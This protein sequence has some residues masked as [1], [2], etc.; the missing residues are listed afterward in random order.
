MFATVGWI[1]NVLN[2]VAPAET[3]ESYDNVGAI[4]GRRDAEVTKILVALDCTLDVVRE[5]K[6]L[7]AELI[8][9]HHPL[10]FHPRKN[11]LEEDAEGRILCEMVRSHL[12]LIAA[13][14]NL[15]QTELSGSASCA[16]LLGL[17]NVRKETNYLFLGEFEKPVK[18]EALEGKIARALSFPVRCYGDGGSLIST[19]AIAGGADDGD[20]QEAKALGAQALL[21]GEVRH[22][23]ALAASMSDFVLF[24]GGHYGTEA[25]LVPFLA[26]YLQ[27]RLNDVQCNV[28]VYP[29]QCAPFGSV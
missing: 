4:I 28:R 5:A 27:K 22:H 17:Q 24:D 23:N 13:H 8:V 25:P 29:S 6:E 16:R 19:L 20:W 18:A 11:L 12:S 9:T 15:D 26:E 1:E 2:E 10:L 7:G 14:T 21:T 3:A